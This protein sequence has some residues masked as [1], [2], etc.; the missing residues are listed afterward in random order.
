MKNLL[1]LLLATNCINAYAKDNFHLT[2][3]IKNQL[4]DTVKISYSPVSVVYK[5]VVYKAKLSNGDFSL[6][7]T[8]P[9][10][11]TN[12][13]ITNG[14]Q[15]TEIY[16]D[17]GA[18]LTLTI[19]A[20]NFDSTLHYEGKGSNIANYLA[21]CVLEKHTTKYVDLHAQ[22]LGSKEPEEYKV[23]LKKLIED[24]NEYID[25]NAKGLPETFISYIRKANQYE[26]WYT[27][28]MYPFRHESIRQKT[29]SV[30]DIPAELYDVTDGIPAMF[31]DKLLPMGS[32]RVYLNNFFS[33]RVSGENAR[34]KI[35]MEGEEWQ[36]TV[37][38]RVYR[39]MPPLSAEFLV[40]YHIYNSLSNTRMRQIDHEFAVYKEHFP[41]SKNLAILEEAFQQRR[42][43]TPGKP[44]IDFDITTPDGTKM[45]LSDLKGKVVY[46]DFWSR[47]CVPCIG[48]MKDAKK[49]R[50]HFA[51]KPVAFVYV[52]IDEDEAT[53]KGAVN[54]YIADGINTHLEKGRESEVV[55]KY[56]ADAIPC[57]FIVGKDG[58]FAAVDHVV[59]PSDPDSLIAQIEQLLQ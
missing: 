13:R 38:A 34:K 45:K 31:D 11:Y 2:G 6:G 55:K 35:K 17:P 57:H 8:I 49:V 16:A 43:T 48:E 33:S 50:E 4:A 21:K 30:K 19:D 52:S 15:E 18:D 42:L 58:R 46:I 20:A 26:V 12:L 36:D 24:E 59:S 25:K 27:M 1:F 56:E 40:A 3:H 37:F 29:M 23:A 9:E 51:G 5:P 22:M 54:T 10:G 7:F 47:G 39:E 44:E 28:H 32:Y 14:N 53:W 41:R